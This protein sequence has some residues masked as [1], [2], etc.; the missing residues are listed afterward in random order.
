M[1]ASSLPYARR[2]ARAVWRPPTGIARTIGQPRRCGQARTTGWGAF[3]FSSA[4]QAGRR[5]SFGRWAATGRA[6]DGE[7]RSA[8]PCPSQVLLHP[9]QPDGRPACGAGH[10]RHSTPVRGLLHGRRTRLLVGGGSSQGRTR[11][12]QQRRWGCRARLT[13]PA[14]RQSRDRQ[15][16]G[17]QTQCGRH[18]GVAGLRD[19]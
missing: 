13:E 11:L 12:A 1:I 3:R 8:L 5:P 19:G 14:G 4:G 2:G 6:R 9:A 7:S 15:D 10:R 18:A 16:G 17:R